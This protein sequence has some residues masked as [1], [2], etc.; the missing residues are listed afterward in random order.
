MTANRCANE[1]N[2]REQDDLYRREADITTAVVAVVIEGKPG[3]KTRPIDGLIA[4]NSDV[5]GRV[6]TPGSPL[7]RYF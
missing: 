6:F 3:V 4:L 1:C 7:D 2:S 5:E